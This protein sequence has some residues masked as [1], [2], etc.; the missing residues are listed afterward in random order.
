MVTTTNAE[1]MRQMYAKG[2]SSG[3]HEDKGGIMLVDGAVLC[4]SL[5]HTMVV[6]LGHG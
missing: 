4:D 2:K 3:Y 1:D 5:E 6:G